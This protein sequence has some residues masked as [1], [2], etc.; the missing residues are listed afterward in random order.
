MNFKNIIIELLNK[1]YELLKPFIFNFNNFVLKIKIVEKKFLVLEKTQKTE[2]YF[3]KNNMWP[4]FLSLSISLI[5]L[6]IVFFLHDQS[7]FASFF[8]TI[9]IVLFFMFSLYGWFK[10]LNTESLHEGEKSI[11]ERKNLVQGFLFFILIEFMTFAACF[12]VLFHCGLAPSI[13]IGALWPGEG[14]VNILVCEDVSICRYFNKTRQFYD[15]EPCVITFND[16]GLSSTDYYHQIY[17]YYP[18]KFKVHI[19]LF[20]KGQLINPYHVPLINTIILLTSAAT[21]TLSH[22]SL[23]LEKYFLSIIF[24]ITTL[25]LGIVFVKIQYLEY[26]NS[27]ISGHDGI[28]GNT[29]FAITGLHGLHVIIGVVFLFFCLINLLFKRY[30]SNSHRSFEFAIWYWHFVD[31]IW[32]IVYFMLYLWPASFFFKQEMSIWTISDNYYCI[33]MSLET[34]EN[35]LYLNYLIDLKKKEDNLNWVA[36]NLQNYNMNLI[37]RDVE[38]FHFFLDMTRE[39]I[40]INVMF[41][42]YFEMTWK[43]SY[44]VVFLMM[45]DYVLTNNETR[46]FI[47][48][49]IYIWFKTDGFDFTDF[50]FEKNK[51]KVLLDRLESFRARSSKGM[52]AFEQYIWDEK[53]IADSKNFVKKT[54]QNIKDFFKNISLRLEKFFYSVGDLGYNLINFSSNSDKSNSVNDLKEEAEKKS[55]IKDEA[56]KNI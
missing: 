33:N 48:V 26:V 11:S 52:K 43:E 29:F 7:F 1:L 28:Y 4:F 56:N 23:K 25:A 24:L 40:L 47:I 8:I 37:K 21:V 42:H 50:I 31:V 39:Y 17:P 45:Y 49:G 2:Y 9:L 16:K 35:I 6:K 10:N 36:E 44:F 19:N 14:I 34:Y 53:Y 15:L 27:M 18:N 22:K 32:I 54:K 38:H 55:N 3:I 41:H 13:W 30:S 51:K 5:L 12:W 46:I 20:D